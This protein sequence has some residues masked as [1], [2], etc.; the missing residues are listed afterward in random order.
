MLS[1]SGSCGQRNS[2]NKAGEKAV[3]QLLVSFKRMVSNSL[4][5][6]NH[7]DRSIR[8]H[9]FVFRGHNQEYLEPYLQLRRTHLC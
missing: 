6:Q 2:F 8:T 4:E 3:K 9:Y 5:T 7:L 1:I